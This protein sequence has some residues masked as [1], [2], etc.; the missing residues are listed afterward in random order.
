MVNT[1]AQAS[2]PAMEVVAQSEDPPVRNQV[3][4]R[5]EPGVHRLGADVGDIKLVL[6][7]LCENT[8]TLWPGAAPPASQASASKKARRR[9]AARR[10]REDSPERRNPRDSHGN[11]RP[12]TAGSNSARAT[13][14]ESCHLR[15]ARLHLQDPTELRDV[16][17]VRR[18]TTD[19]SMEEK[20]KVLW[21][22]LHKEK[23]T[24][25]SA[26]LRRLPFAMDLRTQLLPNKFKMP[27]LEGY[28]GNKDPMDHLNC[29]RTHLSL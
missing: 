20:V 25:S 15:R 3:N 18:G 21:D 27:V 12:T 22:I 6:R 11:E 19:P 9:A 17:N 24:P 26:D 14:A 8:R 23:P 16:I 28:D 2:A 7:P 10:R 29:F 5:L 4:D 13:Q 1:R